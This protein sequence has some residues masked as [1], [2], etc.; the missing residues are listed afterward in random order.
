MNQEEKIENIKL[1]V[2]EKEL[3]DMHYYGDKVRIIYIIIAL[4]ILVMTPF[5]KD[6]IPTTEYFSVL[7]VMV[8]A[9]FAGL[10]NPKSRV[11]IIFD[12][13]ISIFSLLVFGF[14]ALNSY[15]NTYIDT[16]FVG[17]LVLAIISVFAIYY[18]SKTLRGNL[19]INKNN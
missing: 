8:L 10:T 17:N 12:F 5:F 1:H 7:G 18:S 4:I 2:A 9:V 3:K 16:F 11:I 13:L 19:M 14:E 6:R 15:N